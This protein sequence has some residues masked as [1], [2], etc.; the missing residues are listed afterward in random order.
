MNT[1][2][3]WKSCT[4]ICFR[5][6]KIRNIGACFWMLGGRQA[7]KTVWCC[8][9]RFFIGWIRFQAA[10][11][12]RIGSLKCCRVRLCYA[13]FSHAC[14]MV[15][16]KATSPYAPIILRQRQPETRVQSWQPENACPAPP[17]ACLQAVRWQ[18]KN[19]GQDG[20]AT[21][22]FR[23][24]MFTRQGSLKSI[25]PTFSHFQVAYSRGGT[26]R[27][28]PKATPICAIIAPFCSH[29]QTL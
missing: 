1:K 18:N 17:T 21:G 26:T 7:E 24:P 11:V 16:G 10:Y 19:N 5:C 13:P 15:R 27:P 3:K 28:N 6:P 8:A 20:R 22:L 29:R 12:Y 23:L 2:T 25:L 14:V 9:K 4:N